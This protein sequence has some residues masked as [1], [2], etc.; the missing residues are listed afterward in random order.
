MKPEVPNPRIGCCG[1]ASSP[2]FQILTRPPSLRSSTSVEVVASRSTIFSGTYTTASAPARNS[3]AIIVTIRLGDSLV[4]VSGTM[5]SAN[6]LVSRP[7]RDPVSP[8]ATMP[9][10]M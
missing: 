9:I 3:M 2:A 4:M 6:M 7:P 8:I 1:K 10:G 5:V